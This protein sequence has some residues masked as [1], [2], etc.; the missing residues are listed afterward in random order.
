L[1][2]IGMTERK[3]EHNIEEFRQN[4]SYKTGEQFVKRGVIYE[5]T[6]DFTTTDKYSLIASKAKPLTLGAGNAYEKSLVLNSGDNWVRICSIKSYTSGSIS[7]GGLFNGI[8]MSFQINFTTSYKNISAHGVSVQHSTALKK[9]LFIQ[10]ADGQDWQVYVQT[11]H[12]STPASTWDLQFLSMASGSPGYAYEAVEVDDNIYISTTKPT[13]STLKEVD[14]SNKEVEWSI[15][16]RVSNL[17]E[18]FGG[19]GSTFND[20]GHRKICEI[21]VPEHM[22]NKRVK[23]TMQIYGSESASEVKSHQYWF[24]F[25]I[26]TGWNSGGRIAEGYAVGTTT[27][28]TGRAQAVFITTGVLP[29]A[30]TTVSL[31][32]RVSQATITAYN[33]DTVGR[34]GII[35]EKI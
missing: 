29:A 1:I 19:G 18:S 11:W 14:V 31:L 2:S 24:A 4:D 5:A 32:L 20:S 6:S 7:V 26:G 10:S 34:T 3:I 28:D 25:H 33:S 12:N 27:K 8:Q 21:V 15:S 30:G 23:L 35:I 22:A 16:E 17:L 13:G 9:L